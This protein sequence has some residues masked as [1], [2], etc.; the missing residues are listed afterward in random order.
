MRVARL[1]AAALLAILATSPLAFLFLL[2]LLCAVGVSRVDRS[3]TKPA[4]VVAAACLAALLS[5]RL[6]PD[7]GRFPFPSGELLAALTFCGGGLVVT[8]RVERARILRT[9]FA[10]HAPHR[11][12]KQDAAA[13]SPADADWPE[14]D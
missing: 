1:L 13:Q 10:A 4:V 11:P 6:F 12:S 8:W 9:L 2:V 14:V 7:S 3:A 5:W